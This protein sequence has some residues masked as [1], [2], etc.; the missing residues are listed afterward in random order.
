MKRSWDIGV[1]GRE[2]VVDGGRI[3]CVVVCV[4]LAENGWRVW[5][6][7]WG[8]VDLGGSV[9]RGG[10]GVIRRAKMEKVGKDV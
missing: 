6:G 4:D 8:D 7:N 3:N 10:V 1:E 5:T 2:G 9:K